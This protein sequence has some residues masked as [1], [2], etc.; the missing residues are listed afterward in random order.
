MPV[1]LTFLYQTFLSS[2]S[3]ILS[4]CHCLWYVFFWAYEQMKTCSVME[5]SHSISCGSKDRR[6]QMVSIL[7]Q[8]LRCW[9]YRDNQLAKHVSLSRNLKHS[10]LGGLKVEIKRKVSEGTTRSKGPCGQYCTQAAAQDSASVH[11]AHSLPGEL[12]RPRLCV[13]TSQKLLSVRPKPLPLVLEPFWS[14]APIRNPIYPGWSLFMIFL[15]RIELKQTHNLKIAV[16]QILYCRVKL[17][18]ILFVRGTNP[19]LLSLTVIWIVLCWVCVWESLEG[20][21]KSYKLFEYL[22][23]VSH[24]HLQL[25]LSKFVGI[26]PSWF[27]IAVSIGDWLKGLNTGWFYCLTALFILK[28]FMALSTNWTSEQTD[29]DKFSKSPLIQKLKGLLLLLLF[30]KYQTQLLY[31]IL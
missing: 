21:Y 1:W 6:L 22:I 12:G 20:W 28:S 18:M 5:E 14:T 26:L 30:F 31:Y 15:C 3:L 13:V 11:G 19:N 16:N 7:P 25:P 9:H 29:F 24:H 2:F 8:W 10:L 23:P 27:A 17:Q 4:L